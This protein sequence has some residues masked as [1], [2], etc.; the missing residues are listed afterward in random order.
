MD[1]T[2]QRP[3]VGVGIIIVTCYLKGS[4]YQGNAE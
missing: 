2:K 4:F 1:I 3:R